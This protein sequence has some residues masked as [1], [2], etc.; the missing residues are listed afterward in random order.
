MIQQKHELTD[1]LLHFEQRIQAQVHVGEKLTAANDELS[2]ESM[3]SEHNMQT[4]LMEQLA[5]QMCI[6]VDTSGSA[7]GKGT[8]LSVFGYLMQG[9]FDDDLQ[10]PFQSTITI[11]LLNQLEDS[12]HHTHTINFTLTADPDIISRVTSDEKT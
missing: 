10:W 7:S 9:D 6:R 2:K 12:N 11:Q 8:H 4:A 3:S 5:Q 1:Q